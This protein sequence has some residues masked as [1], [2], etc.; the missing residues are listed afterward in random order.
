M[1]ESSIGGKWSNRA[2]DWPGPFEE[3]V[4]NNK[5]KDLARPLP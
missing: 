5:I 2:K 1:N 3:A 4:T